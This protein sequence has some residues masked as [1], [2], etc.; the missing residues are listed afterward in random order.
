MKTLKLSIILFVFLYSNTSYALA[1]CA[2]TIIA[3]YISP[4]T[5]TAVNSLAMKAVQ[6]PLNIGVGA[7]KMA[8]SVGGMLLNPRFY[9]TLVAMPV[10]VA[11]NIVALP[12]R[13]I[14]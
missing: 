8:G 12:F 7:I 6:I 14:F 1:P 4:E 2:E 11:Y 10:K 13:I 3:S 9:T 5:I